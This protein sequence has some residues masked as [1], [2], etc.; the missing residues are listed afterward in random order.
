MVSG[1]PD[2]D[3]IDNGDDDDEAF[4]NHGDENGSYDDII[5]ACCNQTKC[6]HYHFCRRAPRHI[7][8]HCYSIFVLFHSL[9]KKGRIDGHHNHDCDH[10]LHREKIIS[11]F[12]DAF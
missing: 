1:E 5:P 9:S 3:I 12:L 7:S 4:D 11:S 6:N 10:L 8:A 2:N